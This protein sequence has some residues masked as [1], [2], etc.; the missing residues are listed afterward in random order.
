LGILDVSGVRLRPESIA[1]L[2]TMTHLSHLYV[3]NCHLSVGQ[4]DQ[5]TRALPHTNVETNNRLSSRTR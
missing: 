3:V 1:D 2:A 4:I 5:L